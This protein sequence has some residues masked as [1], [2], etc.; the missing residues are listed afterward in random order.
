M[1]QKAKPVFFIVLAAILFLTYV[2]F[3][4]LYRYYG[5]MSSGI[6]GAGKIRWGIDIRGGVDATFQPDTTEEVTDEN[7]DGAITILQQRL[8]DKGI[9]DSEVIG[10]YSADRI[11]VRFPW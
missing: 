10:D 1:R 7:I 6:S 2:A 11:I 4:G 9:S 5:D 3:F 8:D